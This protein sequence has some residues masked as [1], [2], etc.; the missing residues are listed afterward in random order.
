MYFIANFSVEKNLA[1]YRPTTHPFK[2]VFS[3]VTHIQEE[4]AK[5]PKYCFSFMTLPNILEVKDPE[6]VPHL[7][8]IILT[9]EY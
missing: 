4:S 1:A 7:I 6:E 9:I 2:I 3:K 5:L 8:G